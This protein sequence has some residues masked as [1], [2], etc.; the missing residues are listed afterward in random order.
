MDSAQAV[1]GPCPADGE[2]DSSILSSPP[3]SLLSS[4][5]TTPGSTPSPPPEMARLIAHAR[6]FP[7]PS[8]PASQQT[9]PP[10]GG[11]ESTSASDK[12]GPPP[13]KRRKISKERSTEYLDLRGS[14]V[15]PHQD[16][17]LDQLLRVLHERR[18]IVVIAGAGI[19]VSA[20]S[21]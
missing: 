5:L 3:S 15:P 2:G 13:A 20:G 12:E 21:K 9:T 11:M 4:P 14:E 18:K 6:P 1:A 16:P 17:E 10:P 19:S 7:Y 8:P